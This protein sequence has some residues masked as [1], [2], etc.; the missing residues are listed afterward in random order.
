MWASNAPWIGTGYGTQTAQVCVRLRDD[1]HDVAIA[2]NYGHSGGM[3]RWRDIPVFPAGYDTYSNDLIPSHADTWLG[4]RRDEGWLITLMDAWV[5]QGDGWLNH[6]MACWC[7]VDHRPCPP[8]VRDWFTSSGATPIAMSRFGERELDAF[9][10]KPL[11]APH[12]V[13]TSLFVPGDKQA[14]RAE[15]EV[16]ADAFVVLINSA[17]KGQ[18]P[19]RKSWSQMFL[20]LAP[21]MRARDDVHVILHSDPF[22]HAM[23]VPLGEL[24]LAVGL[25]VERVHVTPPYLLRSGLLAEHVVARYQASDVLLMPS[26]GEGFGVPA[27]EAQACGVPVIVSDFSAQPELTGAGWRVAGQPWWDQF[28]RSFLHD[29][30]VESIHQA[31]EDA[32][33]LRGDATVAEQARTFAAEYD[34]D[35]VFDRFW[36]PVVAELERRLGGPKVAPPAGV[37]AAAFG[38]S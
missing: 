38:W 28:Q 9:G 3:T 7:P 19:P 5:F 6:N 20:A 25:D 12:A 4:D 29:P 18:A 2:N 13:D 31:L 1:G 22:G 23:G 30:F 24:M 14:A 27:V 33:V 37:D 17:N 10:F 15:L 8:A 36:R 35:V 26:M 11:Y 34:C 21:F 16:P 32:Y